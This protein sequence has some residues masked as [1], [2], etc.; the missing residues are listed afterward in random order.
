MVGH[1]SLQRAL[2]HRAGHLL[3]QTTLTNQRHTI[4]AGLLDQLLGD[5]HIQPANRPRSISRDGILARL[6]GFRH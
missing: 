2:Q 4:G 5:A 1:L 3:Q 6:I